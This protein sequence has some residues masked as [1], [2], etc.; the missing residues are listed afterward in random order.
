MSLCEHALDH[1]GVEQRNLA[2]P[3]ELP[4]LDIDPLEMFV[5]AQLAVARV[6]L[7]LMPCP[8]V[9][10]VCASPPHMHSV[11]DRFRLGDVDE[12]PHLTV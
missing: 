1:A 12:R 7:S 5:P 4:D 2:D 11:S 3:R 6:F 9:V 10:Q 8:Q